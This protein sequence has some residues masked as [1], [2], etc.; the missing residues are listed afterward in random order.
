[1]ASPTY[2]FLTINARSLVDGSAEA[3]VRPHKPN[4]AWRDLSLTS[5]FSSL[6]GL[7]NGEKKTIVA[8]LVELNRVSFC[9]QLLKLSYVALPNTLKCL[10]SNQP[11]KVYL[12]LLHEF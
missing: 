3:A 10:D 11:P 12:G 8:P 1:M 2:L 9:V 6:L 4:K 5:Y 7:C